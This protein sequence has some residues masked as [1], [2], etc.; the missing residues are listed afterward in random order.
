MRTPMRLVVLLTSM[1]LLSQGGCGPLAFNEYDHDQTR[2]MFVGTKFTISLP[3]SSQERR[4]R[5]KGSVIRPLGSHVDDPSE[6]DVF[7]FEAVELGEDELRIATPSGKD[8]VLHI[9]VK[10][11]SDEPTVHMHQP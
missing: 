10:S 11:A 4:P 8:F 6:M 9:K 5:L 7:D 2:E 1:L 3:R